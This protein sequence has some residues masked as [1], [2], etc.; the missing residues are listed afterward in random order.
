MCHHL[1]HCPDFNFIRREAVQVRTARDFPTPLAY[2]RDNHTSSLQAGPRL[3]LR[4]RDP[5]RGAFS[6]WTACG[7][8]ALLSG[9]N[10]IRAYLHIERGVLFATSHVDSDT[11]LPVPT[12]LR[13]SRRRDC[14]RLSSTRHRASPPALNTLELVI[15]KG[16][17][18]A[19]GICSEPPADR[20]TPR[21][22]GE[23]PTLIS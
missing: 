22:M 16:E 14:T 1:P 3:A 23:L 19:C 7:V 2:L 18:I 8:G 9:V 20:Q 5:S 4:E 6:P 10:A 15:P 21:Y 11:D 12:I 13:T 17:L